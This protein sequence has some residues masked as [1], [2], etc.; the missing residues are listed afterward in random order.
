[1]IEYKIINK[2]NNEEITCTNLLNPFVILHIIENWNFENLENDS[3]YH[4]MI[5]KNYD[6]VTSFYHSFTRKGLLKKMKVVNK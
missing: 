5:S 6:N 2:F 4:Y 3:K 1:M